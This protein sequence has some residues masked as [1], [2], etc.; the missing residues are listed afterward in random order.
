MFK[1]KIG[2]KIKSVTSDEIFIIQK[3][4]AE[5]ISTGVR[6]MLEMSN[7]KLYS[8]DT[9]YKQVYAGEIEIINE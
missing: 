5:I 3:V 7:G 1:L 6:V 8:A 4:R 2:T 9:A